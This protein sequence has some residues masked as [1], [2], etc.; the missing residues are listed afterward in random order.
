MAVSKRLRYEILRRDNHTCRYCGASAPD[1][2]LTVDHVL[3]VALGGGDAPTNLVTACRDCNAGKSSSN[4][5]Q[6]LVDDV[7]ADALRWAKARALAS[8]QMWQH[9]VTRNAQIADLL[10]FWGDRFRSDYADV[11]PVPVDAEQ[12]IRTWLDCGLREKE[13]LHLIHYAVAPKHG[14]VAWNNLWNYFAGCC[15]TRLRELDA[16]TQAIVDGEGV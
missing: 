4:P 8:E 11:P 3:P 10:E 12:A 9:D 6:P 16:K 14:R 7:S 13:M 5:D 15:W 1:V 2:K